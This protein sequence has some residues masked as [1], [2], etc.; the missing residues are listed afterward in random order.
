MRGFRL[1]APPLLEQNLIIR[2]TGP[3]VAPFANFR[4]TDLSM[5]PTFDTKVLEGIGIAVQAAD[6]DYD[7]CIHDFKFRDAA[8]NE[9]TP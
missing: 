1:M 4:Q 5:S 7:Y 9:V 3:L 8:G 6:T 2:D